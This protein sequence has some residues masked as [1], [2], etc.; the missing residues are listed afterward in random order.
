VAL[1]QQAA[2]ALAA[3]FEQAVATGRF[4]LRQLFDIDYHPVAGSDPLQHVCDATAVCDALVPPIIEPVKAAHPAIAFI[5]PCDRQGYIA[6][7]NREYSLPQRP[8]ERVW[9]IA[10]SRNRRIFDDRAGLLAARNTRPIL[11][12]AYVRDMGHM[13]VLLKEFDA[14]VI[15]QGRPWGA[16]R[17]ALKLNAGG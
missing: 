6:T 2:A 12:Q 9:N 11:I 10:N 14:P 7:H 5:A 8:G 3:A 16:M 1:S 15:V 13:T 4:S 17:L